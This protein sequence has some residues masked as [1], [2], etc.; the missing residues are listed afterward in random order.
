MVLSVHGRLSAMRSAKAR[1]RRRVVSLPSTSISSKSGGDAREPVRARR[2][3]CAICPSG[4]PFSVASARAASSSAAWV[5]GSSGRQAIGERAHERRRV[6]PAELPH[7]G[8]VEVR[9]IV[10][11][12]R[13]ASARARRACA[14]GTDAARS[15][16]RASPRRGPGRRTASAS[17]GAARPERPGGT[18]RSARGASRGRS[19]R[20]TVR[21]A[22]ARRARPSRRA[23]SA[24]GPR[25]ATT[26]G[27][28]G[29]CRARPGR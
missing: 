21:C 24:R 15:P 7:A 12:D 3:G 2:A 1:M 8:R 6:G 28:R 11:V 18:V 9:R 25:R 4:R 20:A 5:N 26:R 16:A 27:A 22:R 17:R 10:A 29:N 19:A 14:R 23:S 13:E